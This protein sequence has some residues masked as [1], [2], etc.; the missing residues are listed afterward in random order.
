M[1]S[2]FHALSLQSSFL[3]SLQL[4]LQALS[5]SPNLNPHTNHMLGFGRGL[6]P[7]PT[8]GSSCSQVLLAAYA[9][10][11]QSLLSPKPAAALVSFFLST[12]TSNLTL[13][14]I[15]ML[16]LRPGPSASAS[17]NKFLQ[18]S[19]VCGPAFSLAA[20]FKPPSNWSSRFTLSPSANPNPYTSCTL[21][22]RPGLQ[23]SIHNKK[24]LQPSSSCTPRFLGP[25]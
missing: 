22:L 20:A 24:F 7:V 12:V 8:T 13:N 10:L 2:L 19:Y 15:V 18:S 5:L 25:F 23:S 6:Q 11:G 14:L 9:S 21:S 4:K 1:F 16:S 17:T 3:A